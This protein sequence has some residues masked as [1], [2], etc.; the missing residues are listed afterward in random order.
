MNVIHSCL[1]RTEILASF[2]PMALQDGNGGSGFTLMHIK[3]PVF[4]LYF[5]SFAMKILSIDA[6]ANKLHHFSNYSLRKTRFK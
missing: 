5:V 3:E 4:P 1:S 6:Y 2:R